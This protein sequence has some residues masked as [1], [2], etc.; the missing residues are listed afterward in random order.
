MSESAPAPESSSGDA[1]ATRKPAPQPVIEDK[2]LADVIK[3]LLGKIVTFVNAESF[4]EGGLGHKV[5][6][7]WYKG[8]LAGLGKDYLIVVTEFKHG[9]GKK[10]TK[11]PVKQ[12]VPMGMVKRISVMKSQILVHI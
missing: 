3:T 6:A 5:E 7:S 11:E 2:S 12:Y 8:R 4:E 10:G 1:E 9:T